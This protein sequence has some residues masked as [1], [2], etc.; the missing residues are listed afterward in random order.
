MK[1]QNYLL[2]TL[3]LALRPSGVSAGII[4]LFI[5]AAEIGIIGG[6]AFNAIGVATAVVAA[7]AIAGSA[8]AVAVNEKEE[9]ASKASVYSVMSVISVSSA[10]VA[11][12]SSQSSEIS[13]SKESVAVARAS[14]ERGLRSG[15]A[16]LTSAQAAAAS[17]FDPAL[18]V[19]TFDDPATRS[20]RSIQPQETSSPS[21]YLSQLIRRRM[22][23]TKRNIATNATGWPIAPVGVPQ[24]NFDDCLLDVRDHLNGGGNITVYQPEGVP[25]AVQADHVPPRCMVLANVVLASSATGKTHPVP[26]GSASL[27]WLGVTEGEINDLNNFFKSHGQAPPPPPA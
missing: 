14:D 24:F 22:D 3:F 21:T 10:S 26:F 16:K 8:G 6:T 2:P 27:R 17:S 9:K 18:N 7:G 5:L 19:F 20:K 1:I 12:V 23:L 13:A 15:L 4:P 25:Q 11:S